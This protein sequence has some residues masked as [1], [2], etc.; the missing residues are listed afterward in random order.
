MKILDLI[1]ITTNLWSDDVAAYVTK[2]LLPDTE[3]VPKW[4]TH[5][6]GSI[7][8]EYD[9]VLAAPEIVSYCQQAEAEGYDAVFVD[10]FGDPA[11]RAARECVDIPVFGGFEP[12]IYSALGMADRIGIVTVLPHVV[13]M[14]DGLIAKTGMRE[15]IVSL[16]YVN[17]AVL[18]LHELSGL[19][20]SLVAQAK[21]AIENER[22]GAIVLGCTAM[23]GVKE[24]VAEELQ[25][26]GYQVPVIEAAQAGLIMLES[27]VRMG[28]K[29]S[30]LCYLPPRPKSRSWWPGNDVVSS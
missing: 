17:I 12:A 4:L 29:Q 21:Q 3:V 1:P 8:G 28:W 25:N 13:S 20:A 26:Q 14:L 11:V 24:A 23:V 2:H 7:E 5:G 16:R 15:R 27:Y 10:C 30:R 22:V 18:D 6:P 9:E 19:V